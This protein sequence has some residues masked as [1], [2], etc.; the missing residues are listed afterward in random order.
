MTSGVWHGR[1]ADVDISPTLDDSGGDEPGRWTPV[2]CRGREPPDNEVPVSVA[3]NA[4]L[5]STPDLAVFTS[6]LSVF[7]HGFQFSVEIRARQPHREHRHGLSEALHEPGETQLLLGVEFSD[8]RRTS[9]ISRRPT[10]T[11]TD[12]P[13][14]WPGGGGGGMRSAQ[15]SFFVAPLPPPGVL[16]LVCA[17]P[18]RG[19]GDTSTTLP[20][21]QIL[22]AATRVT[23]LWPWEP[24]QPEPIQPVSP[25]VPDGSWFAA[26]IAASRARPHD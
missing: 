22:E 23:Q 9:N 17:W 14:L 8:G 13:M 2:P 12:A 26:E 3:F 25:D 6:G 1:L 7:S 16:R 15:T 20:C 4:V 11:S 10:P 19:I 18:V 24:E 21:E 5:A